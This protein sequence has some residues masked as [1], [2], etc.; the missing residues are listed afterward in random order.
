MKRF[1]LPAAR[2]R[3]NWG[4]CP[5]PIHMSTRASKMVKFSP[6][7]WFVCYAKAGALVRKEFD[8][9]IWDGDI[10]FNGTYKLGTHKF[11]WT[12]RA[13]E[14]AHSPFMA[15]S[16]TFREG[17]GTPLQYSCL[18]N[19]MDGGAWK[20]VLHGVVKSRTRLSD[21]SFTLHFHTLEKEMATHSSILAWRIPGT[22]EPSGLPSM[23]SHR[24]GHNWSDLA[25]A[26][27]AV[28][29]CLKMMEWLPLLHIPHPQHL[30]PVPLL[31]TRNKS[32]HNPGG[33]TQVQIR[34]EMDNI[35]L[36]AEGRTQHSC[37]RWS[38]EGAWLRSGVRGKREA[39]RRIT[40]LSK[41]T[42]SDYQ[43]YTVGLLLFSEGRK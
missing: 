14:T 19:P 34:E 1:L 28:L 20:A 23:G 26:A 38:S 37:L 15:S 32:G 27:A 24:V 12:L 30:S 3:E 8:L 6:K 31:T 22:E 4:L 21:F 40:I 13:G 16:P 29:L 35:S 7:T 10:Y 18:E 41:L 2:V 9:D 11:P 42:E 36:G 43:E 17:N 5:G 33:D 39:R 25:A